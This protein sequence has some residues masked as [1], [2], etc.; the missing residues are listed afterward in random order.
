MKKETKVELFNKI[1]KF[2]FFTFLLFF[3]ALYI[4]QATGY[5]E[6]ELHKKTVFTN[7]QIKK[8]EEDIEAGKNVDIEDYVT[9]Y[10]KDYQNKISKMGLAISNKTSNL[11][12][13]GVEV[14][15]KALNKLF[16]D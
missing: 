11:V 1:F 8:F 9:V 4:S 3:V 7:E 12:K 16:E 5:Y 10:N 13:K 14:S 2:V 15:F 6:Y